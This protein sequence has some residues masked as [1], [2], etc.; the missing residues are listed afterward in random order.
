[1]QHL[2][3]PEAEQVELHQPDGGAV[4]LVP[5]EHGA[6]R[7]VAPQGLRLRVEPVRRAHST[8][9][10][11]TMGRSQI[12]MP[13]EWMPRCRGACSSSA[14]SASTSSGMDRSP[15]LL[16]RGGGDA[17]PGVDLL[18]PGVLLARRVAERL[19]DVADRRLGAVGDDVGHLG[20]VAAAVLGVDVLDRLLAPARLD[21][22]VDVGRSVPL[23]RQE[24]LEEQAEAHRVGVGDAERVADRA[25]GGAAAAL[26]VDV[27][28]A[29]EVD[30]VP[31]HEE[32]A[33]EPELLD[34]RQLVLDLAVGARHPLGAPR[35]RSGAAAPSAVRRRR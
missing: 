30:D 28:A 7:L 25:V 3:H 18:R 24:P 2:E 17:A 19:G 13:P 23:G 10:T 8:G 4:V 1:M 27:R 26:A 5:L 12:T 20:G 33:G 34:Q 31:H 15:L 35:R 9:H 6:D 21:V 11:S 29:A 14:A 16:L 32:V 22:D